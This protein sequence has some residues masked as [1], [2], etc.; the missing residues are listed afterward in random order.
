ML[1]YAEVRRKSCSSSLEGIGGHAVW[2]RVMMVATGALR[3]ASPA[4]PS[5]CPRMRRSSRCATT[6]VLAR[7][8]RG[9][10]SSCLYHRRRHGALALHR[11]RATSSRTMRPTRRE[12]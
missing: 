11:P 1:R 3:W 9:R 7:R 5:R 2:R 10:S 8:R 12:Q 4:T 6:S